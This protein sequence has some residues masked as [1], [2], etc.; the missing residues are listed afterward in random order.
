MLMRLRESTSLLVLLLFGAGSAAGQSGSEASTRSNFLAFCFVVIVG[1]ITNAYLIS[2]LRA[3]SSEEPSGAAAWARKFELEVFKP[4]YSTLRD[5][6]L[7]SFV[8]LFLEILMIR[9][10]SSEIRIF[11]YFK[12]F[13]LIACY[14]GFGLGCYLCRRAVNLLVV[15]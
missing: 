10:I 14:L 6:A 4:G 12:N 5:L 11:A 8:A 15:L 13:V 1:L 3:G 9:W 2:L 7:W